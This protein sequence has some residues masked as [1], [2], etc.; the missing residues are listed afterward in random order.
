MIETPAVQ[1]EPD[2]DRVG[3]LRDIGG[4]VG[5]AGCGVLERE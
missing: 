4:D 1:V 5:R 3:H 2:P